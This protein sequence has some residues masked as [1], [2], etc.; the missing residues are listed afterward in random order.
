MSSPNPMDLYQQV[1]NKLNQVLNTYNNLLD[2]QADKSALENT[3]NTGGEN[4]QPT[5]PTVSQHTAIS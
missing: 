1:L 4:T 3:F 2:D 5:I